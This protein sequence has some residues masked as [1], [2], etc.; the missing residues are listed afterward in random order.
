MSNQPRIVALGGGHGLAASLR[1]VRLLTPHVTA[2]VGVAD[3]G[4]SSGRIREELEVVPPGDLRM[5]LAALCGE[6]AWGE[7]WSRVV[8]HRF[9]GNGPLAGHA[10]GN[11]LITALWEETGDLVAGLDWVGALLRTEGRVLPAAIEP[12]ELIATVLG[13]DPAHPDELVEVRGQVRIATTSGSVVRVQIC[14]AAPQACAEAVTAITGADVIILGPGSWF[15][16]VMP[17][18]LIPGIRE[19]LVQSSAVK[20]LVLNLGP[21]AGETTGFTPE[22]HLKVLREHAPDLSLSV[23][24]ADRGR[25]TDPDRLAAVSGGAYV[26]LADVTDRGDTSL[27]DPELLSIAMQEALHISAGAHDRITAWR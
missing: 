6:D 19:A 7:T 18:L 11:L 23:V 22:N 2:V 14:P 26:H 9:G 25:V 27:H 5:A 4:G 16:S 13:G 8:Q 20:I 3:D 17:H 12:I 10:L 15:T 1:A 21:Q 24:I